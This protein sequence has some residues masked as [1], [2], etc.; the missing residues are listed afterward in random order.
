[1]SV[2]DMTVPKFMK[3]WSAE[4]TTQEQYD[5][6]IDNARELMTLHDVISP[7]LDRAWK[8]MSELQE[9]VD[10]NQE[11]AD[12]IPMGNL[13]TATLY[14]YASGTREQLREIQRVFG[15][16]EPKEDKTDVSG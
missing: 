4:E 1:M 13:D 2:I 9:V 5:W 14:C 7:L 6:L 11:W 15:I 12:E 10:E 3:D 8:V 16:W